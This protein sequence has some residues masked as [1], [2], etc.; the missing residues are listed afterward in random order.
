MKTVVRE[1]P[2][3]DE[4]AADAEAEREREL[5]E[6]TAALVQSARYWL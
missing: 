3:I 4:D 6:H 2:G 5:R 1:E